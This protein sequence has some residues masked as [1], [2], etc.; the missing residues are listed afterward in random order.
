MYLL[1]AETTKH[2]IGRLCSLHLKTFTFS[3]SYPI[4][5][6]ATNLWSLPVCSNKSCFNRPSITDWSISLDSARSFSANETKL[7]FRDENHGSQIKQ[8]D[9]R[10]YQP[11]FS[12][13]CKYFFARRSFFS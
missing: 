5:L 1:S 3:A 10:E 12:I 13:S 6:S 4:Y 9:L 7:R 8:N 11:C 2:V